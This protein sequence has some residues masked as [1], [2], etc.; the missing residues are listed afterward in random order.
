MSDRKKKKLC[1]CHMRMREGRNDQE[2]G[3]C[4]NSIANRTF[5]LHVT[6]LHLTPGA[7]LIP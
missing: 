7:H 1:K 4:S 3:G 2:D 5:A 6:D